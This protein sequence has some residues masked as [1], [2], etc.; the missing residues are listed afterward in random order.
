MS[1]KALG[2]ARDF[3]RIRLIRLDE[4]DAPDLDWRDDILYRT[5]P[6]DRLEDRACW[7]VEAVDVA[8]SEVSERLATFDDPDAAHD[9][10]DAAEEALEELTRAEFEERY[11]PAS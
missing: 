8:T 5:P 4:G 3:Y 7:V 1:A 10:L 11:F 6:K 9:F 2:M